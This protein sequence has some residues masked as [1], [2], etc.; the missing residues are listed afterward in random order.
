MPP[1]PPARPSRARWINERPRRSAQRSTACCHEPVFR[2]A[3]ARVAA[4]I[5]AMPSPADHVATVE[6]LAPA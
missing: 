2:E 1:P 3:A 4:E 5:A 6:A